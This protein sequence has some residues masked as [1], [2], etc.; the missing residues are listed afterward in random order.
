MAMFKG[1]ILINSVR[2]G[3]RNNTYPK[4]RDGGQQIFFSKNKHGLLICNNS[5]NRTLKQS[6]MRK[7]LSAY[8]KKR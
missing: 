2:G 6:Y 4:V 3:F 7:A 5:K 1:K 8:N